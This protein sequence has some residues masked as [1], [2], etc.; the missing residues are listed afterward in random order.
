MYLL[1][2]FRRFKAFLN[3]TV[4]KTRKFRRFICGVRL[5]HTMSFVCSVTVRS[6]L[7]P[8]HSKIFP[9]ASPWS[10]FSWLKQHWQIPLF[11]PIYHGD[12]TRF[13]RSFVRYSPALYVPLFIWISPLNLVNKTVIICFSRWVRFFSIQC[14]SGFKSKYKKWKTRIKMKKNLAS[15]MWIAYPGGQHRRSN[16]LRCMWQL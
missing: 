7:P 6:R 1:Y 15:H 3:Y 10:F 8:S 4:M 11:Y 9:F 13:K 5:P 14:E 2:S 12:H 16:N